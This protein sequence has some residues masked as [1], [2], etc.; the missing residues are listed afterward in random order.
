MKRLALVLIVLFSLALL[1]AR[2]EPAYAQDNAAIAINTED[3]ASVFDFAFKVR[4]VMNNVVDNQNAAVAYASCEECQ[5]V[6]TAIQIVLVFS[7]PRVVTPENIALA[8][9]DGCDTCETVA[10]AYQFVFSVPEKFKFSEEA[11]ARIVEIREQIEELGES[12]ENGELSALEL[13]EQIDLL[14]DELRTVIKDDIAAGGEQK[15]NDEDEDVDEEEEETDVDEGEEPTETDTMPTD[16]TETV[17]T[18]TTT[19]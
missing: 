18:T 12:F 6:A 11:W 4:R 17:P 9:N 8:L 15:G 16:T 10:S 5:T 3:G 14:V 2:A 19:P 13:Q 7:Y 1:G